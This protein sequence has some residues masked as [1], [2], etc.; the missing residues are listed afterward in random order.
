V[1]RLI[2]F[3]ILYDVIASDHRPLSFAIKAIT[4]VVDEARNE[5]VKIV[6]D[7]KAACQ[8]DL[9]CFTSCLLIY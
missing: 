6:S 5:D 3:T 2:D 4:I 1:P 8:Y 9:N 7:W